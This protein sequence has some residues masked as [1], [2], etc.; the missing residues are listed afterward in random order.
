MDTLEFQRSRALNN[1]PQKKL[2]EILATIDAGSEEIQIKNLKLIATNRYAESNIPIEYWDLKMDKDFVGDPRLLKRYNEY[3]SDLKVSYLEGT[4][5]CF[6]GGHGLGKTM[7]ISCI[8]KK[9]SQKGYGCLYTTLSD[10]VNTLTQGGAEDKFLARR[11]LVM[12]DFLAIDE[13][14]PRFMPS[15]NAADLYARTLESV[16]RTRS[17]NKLPTL[18]STNSPNVVESFNG[19]M[20]ASIDSLMKGY[21]KIFP[22][23][24]DDIRKKRA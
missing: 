21:L 19:P 5:V 6:A 1:I 8:L 10:I 4:S 11:E 14:D 9:A 17:Q 20:K 16:F 22:V 15:D 3:V 7:T 12:I 23:F 24:G 2:K 18:M 13:F